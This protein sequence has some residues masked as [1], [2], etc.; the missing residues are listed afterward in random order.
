MDKHV[1]LQSTGQ[2]PS[3]STHRMLIKNQVNSGPIT[4][5]DRFQRSEITKGM[6]SDNN[7]I[8]LKL[9]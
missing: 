5:L 9:R 3:S 4:S 2:N 1:R 6:F 8:K 7:S